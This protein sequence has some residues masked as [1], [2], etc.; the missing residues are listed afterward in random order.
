VY[1]H[2]RHHLLNRTEFILRVLRNIVLSGLAVAVVLAIGVMGY[3]FLNDEKWVDALVDASMILSGM[4]PVG[5]L[6]R[7]SAKIFASA[8]ALFS[9]LFFIALLGFLLGPF[10]HRLMHHFHFDDE[11]E[12]RRRPD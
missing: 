6:K 7:T 4:G 3:H 9:G 1:E 11:S 12:A 5:D 2:R 8:Y 10:L